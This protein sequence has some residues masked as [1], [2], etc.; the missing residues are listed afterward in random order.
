MKNSF[1]IISGLILC[2]TITNCYGQNVNIPD[3]NFKAYLVGNTDINTNFDDEIQVSEAN[4][5]SGK[6]RVVGNLFEQSKN[7]SDLTGIEAFTALT[8]LDCSVNGNQLTSIDVSK[9]TALTRLNCSINRLTS[10]D[11]SK[12][13]ALTNLDCGYNLLTSLDVSKNT[14]LTNLDC[15]YNELTSLDVSKNTALTELYCADNQ[16]DCV[17]IRD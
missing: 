13:T 15:I 12:N 2:L 1:I 4:A 17:P 14:A 10:I 6:I 16:F 8:E 9:N 3:A 11:V 5:F 7:I